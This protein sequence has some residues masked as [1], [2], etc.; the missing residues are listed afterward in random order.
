MITV[1]RGNVVLT[2]KEDQASRY[3]DM[4]YSIVDGSGNVVK[5]AIPTDLGT[6]QKAYRDHTKEIQLLKE[7]I[8]R[9]KKKLESRPIVEEVPETLAE[10]S[11]KKKGRKSTKE[12]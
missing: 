1:E 11:P 10:E 9:L 4:G 6:L 5:A 7:E 2:I 3:I 8:Q 12:S